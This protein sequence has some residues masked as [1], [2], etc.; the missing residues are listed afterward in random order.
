MEIILTQIILFVIVVGVIVFFIYNPPKTNNIDNNNSNVEIGKQKLIELKNDLSQGFITLNNYDK[1]KLEI[2]QNLAI[3]L[4]NSHDDSVNKSPLIFTVFTV[5]TISLLSYLIYSQV[6]SETV[7]LPKNTIEILQNNVERDPNDSKSWQMLG[8]SLSL[9]G[10]VENAKNAYKK[11]YDLGNK[12]I[13]LLTEYASVLATL[14]QS[15]FTGLRAT[16]IREALEIDGKSVKALYLAG[17]IAANAGIFDLAKGLWKKSL[18]FSEPKS[19]DENMLLDVL[20][21]LDDFQNADKKSAVRISVIVDIPEDIYKNHF[22]NFIMIYAK[23]SFGRPMPIA[24]E[25][26]KLKDFNGIIDLTDENSV[27]PTNKLS[28]AKNIV[29]V[30]RISKTGAAFKQA[31]DIDVVSEIIK[32]ETQEVE[33]SF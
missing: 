12:D 22:D 27:M 7:E 29:I 30:A 4:E 14:N 9:K 32:A 25:K 5:F 10:E 3:E 19:A 33:L 15:Q 6:K 31:G 28:D 18:K 13:D 23:N 17:I 26:I 11:S 21:Q 20:K 2:E 16:L 8:V 1:S 24:I